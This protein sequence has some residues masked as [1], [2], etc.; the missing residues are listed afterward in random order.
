M[1]LSQFIDLNKLKI[2]RKFTLPQMH[3]IWILHF[4][5]CSGTVFVL[6]CSLFC[7]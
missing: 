4:Q 3:Q 5:T 1:D 2:T 6:T 7:W